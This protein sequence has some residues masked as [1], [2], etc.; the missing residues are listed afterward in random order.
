MV[1]ADARTGT[2][3]SVSPLFIFIPYIYICTTLQSA[4]RAPFRSSAV[5]RSPYSCSR[6][7]RC[8]VSPTRC[9]QWILAQYLRHAPLL[10]KPAMRAKAHEADSQVSPSRLL[11]RVNQSA[12]VAPQGAYGQVLM[13]KKAWQHHLRIAKFDSPC[14]T[15]PSPRSSWSWCTGGPICCWNQPSGARRRRITVRPHRHDGRRGF[16]CDHAAP[17]H[18]WVGL[19]P[20]G[21]GESLC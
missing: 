14:F 19:L 10:A 18:L 12:D 7:D 3:P 20:L 1:H 15:L 5:V 2:V 16:W 6:A 4:P 8:L 9:V 11:L 13:C 21:S 17:T